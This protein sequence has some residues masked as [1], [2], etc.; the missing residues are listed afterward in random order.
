VVEGR[1][2]LM[3]G[4]VVAGRSKA[5]LYMNYSSAGTVVDVSISTGKEKTKASSTAGLTGWF[6]LKCR[7]KNCRAV[8]I[9]FVWKCLGI[10]YS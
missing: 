7:T 9:P 10:N 6:G 2:P 5:S 3:S 1:P 4:F 8:E